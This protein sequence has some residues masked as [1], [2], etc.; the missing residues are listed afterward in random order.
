[1]YSYIERNT[2]LNI[3]KRSNVPIEKCLYTAP[4]SRLGMGQGRYGQAGMCCCSDFNCNIY[5]VHV[6]GDRRTPQMWSGK[7]HYE[8]LILRPIF[9]RYTSVGIDEPYRRAQ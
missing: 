7:F 5:F 2:F 4:M 8:K 3:S 9:T 6:C 1:M